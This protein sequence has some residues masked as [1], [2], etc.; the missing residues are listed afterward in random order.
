MLR[1]WWLIPCALA[2]TCGDA[3][4]VGVVI[5]GERIPVIDMHLHPGDWDGVPPDTQE[6][7]AER[8]PW[9][10]KLNPGRLAE[11][12][13]SADGIVRELDAAGV[14]V[15]V[16]FAVYAPRTVGI[17]SNSLVISAVA[18]HPDRFL[19]L[20]SLRVDDWRSDASKELSRLE[21]ALGA[22][23]MV[24]VKLAHAHMHFRMDD[25]EYFGI[26]EVAGRLGKP[27]YLHTGNSPFPGIA[28]APEYTDPAY[29]E[30]A[31]AA[32]PQTIFI[33]G[34][35]G[36]D[37]V[38]DEIGELDT[39]IDLARR[40]PNVYLEPSALGSAGN[41]PDGEILLTAFERIKEGE[42]IDRVIYG[43]DGPQSPGFVS[44]YLQRTVTA[45][46]GAEYDTEEIRAVLAGNFIKVFGAE[47]G[48]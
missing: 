44:D 10:F 9:P 11:T 4:P 24:G 39:C 23:G 25:P 37:F 40:Y 46:E 30:P 1:R 8:F 38:R 5:D 14:D 36:Y 48:R 19:G 7:L 15:G 31:I 28:Q 17:A 16:L 42:V 6:F 13:L 26:Y 32:F 20:A 18:E 22:P 45:M 43:S 34:H 29:L 41:D 33:L 2:L 47:A 27:V 21:D 3:E 12:T 35:L